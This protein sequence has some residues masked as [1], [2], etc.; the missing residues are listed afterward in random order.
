MAIDFFAEWCGF[1]K[2]ISPTFESLEKEH[3]NVYFAKVDVDVNAKAAENGS[4]SA[5]PTFNFYKHGDIVNKLVGANRSKL[6]SIFN[7]LA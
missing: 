3:P 5:M 4:V 2:M 7:G 6:K 1:C